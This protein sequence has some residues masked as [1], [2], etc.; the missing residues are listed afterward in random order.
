MTDAK[1]VCFECG[2]K[3]TNDEIGIYKKI[4]NR[5]AVDCL[6][7]DCLAKFVGCEVDELRER[8]EFFRKQGCTL[9]I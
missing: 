5:G 1:T 2:R 4:I 9:F 6:C 3:I 7:I 8:I